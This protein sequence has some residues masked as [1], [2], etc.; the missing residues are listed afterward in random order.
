MLYLHDTLPLFGAH[1]ETLQ[2]L[3]HNSVLPSLTA[4]QVAAAKGC[5]DTHFASVTDNIRRAAT[6]PA[7]RT[8]DPRRVQAV[9]EG[10]LRA[11]CS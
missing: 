9:C 10:G 7:D 8:L 2:H 11:I 5:L 4:K 1:E 3:W 6:L